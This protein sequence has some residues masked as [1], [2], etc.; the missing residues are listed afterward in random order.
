MSLL[1]CSRPDVIHV[2][3]FTQSALDIPALQTQMPMPLARSAPGASSDQPTRDSSA[4]LAHIEQVRLLILGMD[5]RLEAR[6]KVLG[7]TVEK[8]E[9]EAKRFEDLQKEVSSKTGI[10]KDLNT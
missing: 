8:A 1:P 5:Q 10:V 9:K 4:T 3:W 7:K 6:E 2:T